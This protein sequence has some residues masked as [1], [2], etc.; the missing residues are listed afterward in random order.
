[1]ADSGDKAMFV[2]KAKV[3]VVAVVDGWRI[4]GDLHIL[5][6]SR[7]TDAI[8]SKAKDFLAVTDATIFDAKNSSLLFETPYLA[9]NRDAISMIFLSE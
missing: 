6:G 8:N 1:V 3:R 2:T 5:S 4:E 7:L 9:L